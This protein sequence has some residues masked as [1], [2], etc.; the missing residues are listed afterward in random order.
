[1]KDGRKA[2]LLR[3]CLGVLADMTVVFSF[4]SKSS[5]FGNH[6]LALMTSV[7][8]CQQRRVLF[9][10]SFFTFKRGERLEKIQSQTSWIQE[11]GPGK[12]NDLPAT[13]KNPD[14][15]YFISE[16]LKINYLCFFLLS[17]VDRFSYFLNIGGG[18]EYLAMA[19]YLELKQTVDCW[20]FFSHWLLKIHID[21]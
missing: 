9:W 20:K 15:L 12:E 2:R 6:L 1:M 5:Y 4:C 17:V 16:T 11:N 14:R 7:L 21:L 19:S 10:F 18:E 13:Y 3:L 8:F